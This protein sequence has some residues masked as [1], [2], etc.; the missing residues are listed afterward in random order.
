MRADIGPLEHVQLQEPQLAAEPAKSSLEGSV[1]TLGDGLS[2][3]KCP[4][5]SAIFTQSPLL[6][7]CGFACVMLDALQAVWGLRA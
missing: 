3:D 2:M 7:R 4:Q 6:H 1:R 5:K